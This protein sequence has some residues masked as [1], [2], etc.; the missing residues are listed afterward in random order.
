MAY[1]RKTWENRESEY[2]NRRK[3]TEV[4]P[5]VY[6]VDRAEG[7]VVKD[8]NAFED[9]EMNDFE[10]RIEEGIN[11]VAA[12]TLQYMGDV[13]TLSDYRTLPQGIYSARNATPWTIE[14]NGP[15]LPVQNRP[16][17][18]AGTYYVWEHSATIK[19]QMY[20]SYTTTSNTKHD[21]FTRVCIDG[22][23]YPWQGRVSVISGSTLNEYDR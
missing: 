20:V 12:A 13:P 2:P 3:L 10:G 5:G 21:I 8:G 11:E 17:A 22:D 1:Q 19:T 4:S 18:G 7:L 14:N 15:V 9:I 6:D 16:A 23:W